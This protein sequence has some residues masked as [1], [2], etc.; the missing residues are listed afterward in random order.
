MYSL[1]DNVISFLIG[2]AIASPLIFVAVG[3]NGKEVKTERIKVVNQEAEALPT[4]GA[5][6]V[7]EKEI[8]KV[9]LGAFKVTAYCPCVKCCDE[10]A[11]GITYTGVKATEGRT[12][13]VDPSVIPLG[14]VLEIDGKQYVAEDIGG[15]IKGKRIELYFDSH[16][17]ALE[18]GVKTHDVYLVD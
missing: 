6:T 17:D 11:D 8:E 18:W 2:V 5:T 4:A 16:A 12:I 15:A 1:K 7:L 14:S 3:T 13:A 10:W 9:S